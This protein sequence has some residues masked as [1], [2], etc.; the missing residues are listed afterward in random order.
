[1]RAECKIK[2][3][4]IFGC[5]IN[6]HE[7]GSKMLI[8]NAAQLGSIYWAIDLGSMQMKATIRLTARLMITKLKV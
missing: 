6:V 1:M 8:K 2:M 4:S 3:L 5:K 7:E